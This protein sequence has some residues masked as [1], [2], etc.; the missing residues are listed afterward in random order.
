MT[1]INQTIDIT[2][3]LLVA[4]DIE[5][6]KQ[7][8]SGQGYVVKPLLKDKILKLTEALKSSEYFVF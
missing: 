2:I 3:K 6:S 7:I 8:H 1:F 5:R 4:T